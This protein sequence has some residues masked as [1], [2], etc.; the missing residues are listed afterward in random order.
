MSYGYLIVTNWNDYSIP[1]YW[2]NENSNYAKMNYANLTNENLSYDLNLVN[3]SNYVNLMNASCLNENSI[4]Y[5][6]N[7]SYWNVNWIDCY[8]NENYLRYYDCWNYVNCSQ[9]CLSYVSLSYEMNLN[10]NSIDYCSNANC[11]NGYLIPNYLSYEN[12]MNAKM[13][14]VTN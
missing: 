3:F 8:S 13:N 7:V 2:T 5:Y 10:G 6:W 4:D 11:S 1:N 12:S 9:N 14:Y